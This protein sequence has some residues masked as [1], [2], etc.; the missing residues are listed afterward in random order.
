MKSFLAL[1]FNRIKNLTR[2]ERRRVDVALTRLQKSPALMFLFN[3]FLLTINAFVRLRLLIARED[4]RRFD[5]QGLMVPSSMMPRPLPDPPRVL[6]IVEDSIEQCFRYRVQQK[7]EQLA[8]LHVTAEWVSWRENTLAREKLHFNDIIIFYRV[9]G[10]PDVL[11]TIQYARAINKMVVYDV[12]DLVFDRERLAE[13]FKRHSGQLSAHERK[14]MLKGAGLYQSALQVCEFAITTT[15]PLKREIEKLLGEGKVFVL[16]NGLDELAERVADS[17]HAPKDEDYIDLFYGSGTKTHDEDFESVSGVLERLLSEF[18]RLRLIVV[19]YLTLPESF[20]TYGDRVIKLP[21]MPF[22]SYLS[23]LS[24]ADINIAPLEPG[25]FADCKSEIKWLEAGRFNIPSIVS[26]TSTYERVITHGVDGFAVMNTDDWYGCLHELIVDDALRREIGQ[27]ACKLARKQYGLSAMSQ[28][29]AGIVQ[30]VVQQSQESGTLTDSP[31]DKRRILYVNTVYPPNAIGGA[32]VVMKNTID[33]IRKSYAGEFEALVFTCD[34]DNP[35]PYQLREYEWEGVLVTAL[36]IPTHPDVEWKYE[37]QNVC[38]LF[39][40]FLEYHKPD[41]VHFHSIQ[42][43]TGSMLQATYE[44]GIRFV[45]TVHDAWWLSDYQFLLDEEGRVVDAQQLNAIIAASTSKDIVG[46][47]TRTRYL[48]NQLARAVQLLAVSEY[49]AG[50]YK[51]NGFSRILVNK[52]G[53]NPFADTN[54]EGVET[55]KLR[56]GYVGG[57]C[58]HKGYYFLKQVVDKLMLENLEIHIIDF[59]LTNGKQRSERWGGTDVKFIPK[60]PAERMNEF[61]EDIEILVAPSLWPE[62]F[63]LVTREAT[64]MGRW[65]VASDAGGLSEDLEPGINSH[66]FHPG[67]QEA[68]K[69]ILTELDDKYDH[70]RQLIPLSEKAKGKVSSVSEQVRQ[71]VELYESLLSH[72]LDKKNNSDRAMAC[73][74]V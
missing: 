31:R 19:G 5:T 27:R 14:A 9:P 69:N 50:L 65:V 68:L 28:N 60:L 62:S 24:Q 70:Y 49:Q 7:L 37:D 39:R 74:V 55:S 8:R 2:L 47:I 4:E 34:V 42:R 46:S 57:L 48:T 58:V 71:L 17:P 35:I 64:L 44:A 15:T 61:Y 38:E 11:K 73:R 12:D 45:V 59:D 21:I 40:K 10:F 72:R 56:L 1:L 53:V 52:N 54:I 3:A 33:E 32:T 26:A 41:L 63:G 43:L 20:S 16:A 51:I 29:L 25:V 67:D 30:S 22:E 18:S 6:L 23:V 13:K 36:S 66:V